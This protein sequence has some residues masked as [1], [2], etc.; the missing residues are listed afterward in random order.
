VR[1]HQRREWVRVLPQQHTAP[2]AVIQRAPFS[3][4]SC[5]CSDSDTNA[6][7]RSRVH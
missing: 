4:R 3:G 6:A 2:H 1:L 5:S 7:K